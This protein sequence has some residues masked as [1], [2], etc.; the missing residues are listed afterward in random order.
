MTRVDRPEEPVIVP[1]VERLTVNLIEPASRALVAA[2][3]RTGLSRTDTVNRA[4][5]VYDLVTASE[6][7]GVYVRDP[8]TGKF[9]RLRLA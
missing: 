5:Q 2:A 4:L 1:V 6:D 7:A 9:E 3:R 8:A